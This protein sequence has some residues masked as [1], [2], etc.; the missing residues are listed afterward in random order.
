MTQARRCDEV[1][2]RRLDVNKV[3][4]FNMAYCALEQH[5]SDRLD[6]SASVRLP[7]RCAIGGLVA[8]ASTLGSGV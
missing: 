2:R 4:D 1:V 7:S 5:R 6:S 3:H 8:F